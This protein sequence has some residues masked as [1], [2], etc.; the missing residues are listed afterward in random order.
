MA[1]KIV[2][3]LAGLPAEVTVKKLVKRSNYDELWISFPESE[4]ICP[5]CSSQD[6]I[7]KDSGKNYTVYHSAVHHR[8]T[9]LHMQ[10]KRYYCKSCRR[11]FMQHPDWLHPTLHIT[12]L[13]HIDICLS[14]TKMLSLRTV[15]EENGVS[16]SIV[17]SVL[18]LISFDTVKSLPQTIAIDEFKGDSST[19]SSD[20][21]RWIKAKYHTNIVDGDSRSVIDILPVIRA[22][23]L[24][25]YF[26]QF[27]KHERDNVHFYCCDMHNGF[28]SV[29]R[30][31]F[32][33]AVIC[34]DMFHVIKH[35]NDCVSKIRRQLQRELEPTD[36]D[37]KLL[38]GS[39][40]MLIAKQSSIDAKYDQK[41]P[42]VKKRL[43]NC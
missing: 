14:L 33:Q 28:V 11:T 5:H 15:A 10:R 4:R 26:R 9:H 3:S 18:D 17:Y 23:D 37:Y 38:K 21:Q 22:S 27:P 40:R 29:A 6:C 42:V 13:L 16:E 2:N 30:D 43:I 19:W 12:Q 20:R 24:K 7:I 36:P 31:V 34:I 41:A 35:L 39:M 1:T 32:P 8:S 25:K